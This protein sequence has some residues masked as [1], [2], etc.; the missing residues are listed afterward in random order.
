MTAVADPL[1][2]SARPQFTVGGSSQASLAQGLLGLMIE[3]SAAGLRHC[4]ATFANWG[5]KDGATGFLY[6]DRHLLDFGNTVVIEGGSG[7][8]AGQIFEGKI[9]ALEGRFLRER[10]PELLVLAEDRLQ[11]LRMTRRTR[12]FENVSDSDL[13]NQVA[14]DYS[15]TPSI[16][17]SGPTHKVL[18]QLNQ[19]DLAFLR[20]RA[21][22]VDAELW[23]EGTTLH[24]QAR[25]RRNAGPAI[26]TI[27]R[28]LFECSVSA[29]LAG[30]V[31][32]MVV[33]GWDVAAKQA[34]S[35]R[36][37]ASVLA[38]ELGQD[39]SGE[40]ILS[41]KFRTPDQQIVHHAPVTS[42]EATALADAHYRRVA[43]RFVR[44]SGSAEVDAR[45]QVGARVELRGVGTLFEG[46]YTVVR[47]RHLFDTTHGFRTEFEAERP[48]LGA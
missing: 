33:T 47:T 28:S 30:Q 11:E 35:H 43:R 16:D 6:F 12:T 20:E 10:P 36:S 29:D 39:T 17:V 32:G 8:G 14:G 25:A 22:A 3:E 2:Y 9:T 34:I 13:F 7:V 27:G 48:G 45:V 21:R 31:T 18:A 4:E 42:A 38:G 44:V 41:Q 1:V 46:K 15:L 5:P 24:V 19:S 23:L 37:S 40:F 26:L